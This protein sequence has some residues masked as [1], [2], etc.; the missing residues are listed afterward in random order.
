MKHLKKLATSSLAGIALLAGAQLAPAQTVT[1]EQ[2]DTL[3]GSDTFDRIMDE[4][5]AELKASGDVSPDGSDGIDNYD[6]GGSSAGERQMEGSPSSSVG[7]D[8]C[9]VAG[10]ADP[11]GLPE[12]NPGCQEIAPMSRQ[13]DNSICE[14][15]TASTQ[16]EGI[17]A[18]QDGIVIIAKNVNYAKYADSAAA[19]TAY[20]TAS[21]TSASTTNNPP[22]ANPNFDSYDGVGNWRD[23]GALVDAA[24]NPTAYTVGLNGTAWRDVARLVYTGFDNND[25]NGTAAAGGEQNRITRCSSQTRRDAVSNWLNTSEGV[26]CSTGNCPNGIVRALRRDDS[27]GTTQ[28]FVEALGLTPVLTGQRANLTSIGNCTPAVTNFTFCDGG[29]A[30]VVLPT[31]TNCDGTRGDPLKKPCC[32]DEDICDYKDDPLV[33]GNDNRGSMGVVVAVR[34]PLQDANGTSPL[35]FPTRMCGKNTFDY[36]NFIASSKPVCPDGTIPSAGRCKFPYF[37]NNGV[38][39]FNCINSRTSQPPVAGGTIDGR[40]WNAYVRTSAGVVQNAVGNFPE[41]STYRYNEATLP[42]GI[43]SGGTTPPAV[44]QQ[45]SATEIIGCAVANTNCCIVGFAGREAA[46]LEPYDNLQEPFRLSGLNPDN[47]NILSLAYPINRYLY[48]NALNGFENIEVDCLAAG[49]DPD[50]CSDQV[51]IALEYHDTANYLPG[52]SIHDACINGGVIPLEF[53]PANPTTTGPF[54]AGTRTSTGNACGRPDDQGCGGD[55]SCSLAQ[56]IPQ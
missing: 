33:G 20:N 31:N 6:G 2:P 35:A 43:Y 34:S 29:D 9:T 49:H 55:R 48:L 18:C 21:S 51:A 12:T 36:I 22:L 7:E 52:G 4:L 13:M 30:E 10:A 42:T 8:T 44:C 25:G 3:T 5:L 53:D 37:L 15:D 27:S 46:V 26:A 14:D 17:A 56:C 28:F 40:V 23:S 47:A 38:K 11:N 19:C 32:D 16:A 41:A 50:Y 24:G 54:C 1:R 39:D 45:G